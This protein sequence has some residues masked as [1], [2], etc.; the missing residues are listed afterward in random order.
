MEPIIIFSGLLQNQQYLRKVLR[1][2]KPSYFQNNSDKIIL[3]TIMMYCQK[4]KTIPTP[5]QVMSDITKLKNIN[6]EVFENIQEVLNE[7][8]SNKEVFDYDWLIQNT[9]TFCKDRAFELAVME[10]AELIDNGDDKN[11]ANKLIKDAL[12]INFDTHLGIEIFN[13]KSIIERIKQYKEKGKIYKTHI[14]RLNDILG[15]GLIEKTLT[16]LMGS[17][18]SGKS[19]S[20]ISFACGF[21]Q[22]G[23]DVLYITLE[24]AEE[25]VAKII[26][27]NILSVKINDIGDMKNDDYISQYNSF[28]ENKKLGK[29][30]VKEFP[31][32]TAG[33]MAFRSL[34]EELKFKKDFAPKILVIDYLNI[35]KCDSITQGKSY[36]IVKRIAEETR[37]L[38]VEG[39]YAGISATQ[40]NRDAHDSSDMDLT[41][42][43][44]SWGLPQTADLQIGIIS[45]EELYNQN[46]LI[47]KILKNRISGKLNIKFPI[48][49]NFSYGKIEDGDDDALVICGNK[50]EKKS[51][52]DLKKDILRKK[53]LG[54]PNV[55]KKQINANNIMES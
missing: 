30:F 16:V 31:T 49:T 9:E 6:E 46:I 42:T 8:K 28:L 40:S 36:E 18:H 53:L 38:I 34:L 39:S 52:E 14:T 22:N 43:S 54:I 20:L 3:K 10:C 25:I 33:V 44:E 47:Y 19:M 11:I 26:D 23:Y 27:A 45:N 5:T 15:G 1:Y 17:T 50:E 4:F 21:V 41:Q 2:L 7:I 35:M 32:T 24:M 13:E 29:L 51:A 12:S 55:A 48:K 37:G